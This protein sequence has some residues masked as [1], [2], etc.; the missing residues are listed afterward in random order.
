MK[1]QWLCVVLISLCSHVAIAQQPGSE[2][3]NKGAGKPI[4]RKQSTKGLSAARAQSEFYRPNEVQSI[5]L[6]VADEDMQRLLAA[7]PER[8]YVPASFQWRDVSIKKVAIRYKGNSSSHPRQQHKRSFLIRFDKYDQDTR[9]F[10]LR[11]VSFDNGIQFGSIFSEPIIT[12]ILRDQGIKTHR[13]NY[14]RVYLNDEYQ[15]VYV[16][17]ERIDESFIEQHLPDANGALFKVDEGGPGC[18]LQFL[19]DDPSIYKKT[20]EAKSESAK[21]AHLRLVE[22]IRTINQSKTSDFA[23]KLEA[24]MELDDFLRTAA[25]MLFSGAFDQLTGWGPHNYYLYHDARRDRWRYLPWDLDVGFCEHAFGRVHVLADWNAAWPVAP[26]GRPN[27][28]MERIVA[29]PALLRRYRQAA[30]KILDKYFEPERLC[31]IIDAKYELIKDDLKSDPFPH[32]R[33]TVPGDRDYDDIV[34]S[35]KTFVRKRYASALEQLENPGPRPKV[36]HRPA[37]GL[38][39]RLAE[40]LKRIERRA[41]QMQKIGQDVSSIQKLMQKVPPLLQ[42]GKADEAEKVFDE[43]LKLVGEEPGKLK[44]KSPPD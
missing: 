43:V 34:G 4:D 33:V 42:Q 15:G 44:A 13:C 2:P 35:I 25:V 14:A 11:R 1:S 7:L 37:G 27:P 9:F 29:D 19:G 36:Q 6:R 17:V 3:L 24:T 20:F 10:G 32:R 8:I 41:R 38:P 31:G 22:F 5:R 16:N 39:R 26:S 28:L 23:A 18:N 21:K 12:E 40:K 30:R